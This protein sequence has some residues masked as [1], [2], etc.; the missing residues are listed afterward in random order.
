M[1]N[2]SHA[3][4]LPHLIE[5]A[6]SARPDADALR[7]RDGSLTYSELYGRAC[8][9][10]NGLLEDGMQAGDRVG[11]LL[12]KGLESAVALYGVMLAGG[13]YVPLDP[14][15][16][17]A[18]IEFVL[19]DCGIQR[20]VAAE[21]TATTLLTLAEA[22][23]E[24]HTV[25]G[26]PDNGALP[27]RVVPWS[28]VEPLSQTAP[29]IATTEQDLCYILYTS[30]STGSPKGIMHTHRSALSWAEVAAATYELGPHDVVSNYAP[31]HFDLSTLDYFAGARAGATTTI[32]PEEVTKFPASLAGFLA[33][34][35]LTVFYTVPMAL[36]HL[37]QPGL[38]EGRDLDR[39]RLV[40]F[41]GEPMPIKHLRRIMELMPTARFVNVYGPTETNGVTHHPVD[42]IPSVETEALPIGRPYPNVDALIVDA[43]FEPVPNGEPGELVVRTPTMMRGYWGRDD[44]NEHAFHTRTPFGGRP[45]VYHRTGDLAA[46]QSDGTIR[47][48]GRKDRQ[49]KSRGNRV[50]LDEVEAV[51]I[52]H[53]L[54]REAAVYA[55]SDGEGLLEIRAEA[56]PAGSGVD[57]GEL[58][59]H[60]RAALP[61]YAVP[62]QIVLRDSFPR[63]STGKIDRLAME[64]EALASGVNR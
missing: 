12:H 54:V 17:T 23:L 32:I 9:L 28:A 43:G 3:Y 4:L 30:G 25:F 50:E 41:G 5:Q 44:L 59:R 33:D 46:M 45:D 58:I 60:L 10:A 56:I 63:T 1:S 18:R 6:A 64:A 38:L 34:E 26:V 39:L 35:G 51:L 2:R 52:S 20:L 19:R 31:L 57:S 42:A 62:S 24:L 49:I 29:A 48:L 37:A 47:F 21:R 22:G 27:Y 15:A 55:M 61:A 7:F 13:T 53:P 8:A 14:F 11:I 36:I 16:P 40:L